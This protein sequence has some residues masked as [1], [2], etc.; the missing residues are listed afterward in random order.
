VINA[1]ASD[2]IKKPFDL[3]ELEAKIARIINERTLRQELGRLS[4]TDALTGLFNQRHFYARLKEE[5]LRS[6]R[7]RHSLALI[8][9]DLD[10]FK[11]YNDTYGHLAGDEML[12][13]VGRVVGKSTRVGVDSG[14]RYGGDEFA[15]ILIDADLSVAQE[16]GKR[17]QDALNESGKMGASLGTAMFAEGMTAEEL[18]ALAD[19]QLYEMKSKRHA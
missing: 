6:Q 8:L 4:I 3:E 1:G 18:V 15:V 10:R 13:T 2:F 12:R 14:Y 19:K 7:Q 17:I 9:L 11:E 5:I 16:I